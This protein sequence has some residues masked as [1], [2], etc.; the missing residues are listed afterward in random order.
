MKRF[1]PLLTIGLLALLTFLPTAS[2]HADVGP[3]PTM[4]FRLVWG[5]PRVSVTDASL[6][7]CE[8]ATCAN[9]V[10]VLGPFSCSEE[11]CRYNYG[12][13]GWYQ[14][15]IVFADQTRVSNIF[16]KLGFEAT[17]D[18]TVNADDL[19]VEQVS[20]PLPY[21]VSLQAAGFI[22]ALLVTLGVEIPL[23]GFILKRW[24]LLRKWKLILFANLITLPI[25]WFAF[26][27]ISSE[28]LI[29][30]GLAELF[31]WL[32]EAGFYFLTMRKEGLT[33]ARAILLS[34][35]ANLASFGIPVL[36]LLVSIPLL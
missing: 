26:P 4:D 29:V 30:I 5:I 17:F 34:L 35:F 33:A 15:E 2:V 1:I 32:F 23:A 9:P 25:V 16:E 24:N 13:P 3:K 6:F 14:L 12:S 31:A 21:L 22:V 20:F 10:E 18:V 7:M 27:F 19:L 36:C 11:S 8:D 28:T